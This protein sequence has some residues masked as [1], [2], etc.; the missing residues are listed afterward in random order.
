MALSSPAQ[1]GSAGSSA[2]A[3]RQLA[4]RRG[5]LARIRVSHFAGCAASTVRRHTGAADCP[6]G[7]KM[8]RGSCRWLGV[9]E[10]V[11]GVSLI[12][13]RHLTLSATA[14]AA[15]LPGTFL[16]LVGAER[17][18]PTWKPY[19]AH[20]GAKNLVGVSSAL[21]LASRLGDPYVRAHV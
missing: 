9:V 8:P 4:S 7:V 10:V 18:I 6:A 2:A 3:D 14:L 20:G 16:V 12:V 15:H 21:V 5:S 1:N 11:L 17:C 13:G 19:A